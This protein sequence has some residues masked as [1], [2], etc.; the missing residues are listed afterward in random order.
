M[1]EIPFPALSEIDEEEF[2]VLARLSD[3]SPVVIIPGTEPES[4]AP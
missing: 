4:D 1:N 3:I 2:P